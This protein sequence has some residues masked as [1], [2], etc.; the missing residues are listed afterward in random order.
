MEQGGAFRVKRVYA[1]PADGD[2]TRVL[3][4]ALWPRGIAKDKARIDLWLKE[5]APSHELRRRTHADPD[6]WH[7]FPPAYAAELTT[8][9]GQAALARLRELAAAGPVTLLFAAKGEVLNNATV[10]AEILAGG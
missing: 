1:P 5:V 6:N 4:D 2:G 7:L 9:A 3:V 10:L 8:P